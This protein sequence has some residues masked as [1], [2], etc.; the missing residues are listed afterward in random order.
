MSLRLKAGGKSQLDKKVPWVE[1]YFILEPVEENFSVAIEL[2]LGS[3]GKSYLV[4]KKLWSLKKL[5]KL[6]IRSSLCRD[7]VTIRVKM[8]FPGL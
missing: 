8:N 5:W 1:S 4:T 6:K 7:P 3:S 2:I